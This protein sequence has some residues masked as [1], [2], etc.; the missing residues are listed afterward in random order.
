MD[1][2]FAAQIV[3]EN[4]TR[5]VNFNE[6]GRHIILANDV[7][8]NINGAKNNEYDTTD[9]DNRSNVIEGGNISN[10]VV[11]S[12]EGGSSSIEEGLN[13]S[14]ITGEKID[15]DEATHSKEVDTT[16]G[17]SHTIV[18]GSHV[19]NEAEG[20]KFIYGAEGGSHRFEG[21]PDVDH[22]TREESESYETTNSY[23]VVDE[24]EEGTHNTDQ[25]YDTDNKKEGEKNKY[26]SSN[27][28]EEWGFDI[29][30]SIEIDI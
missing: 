14:N 24:T 8:Q 1:N 18:G 4:E 6:G 10:A 2:G 16:E 30:Q 23:T 15:T 9:S 5:L 26:D 7:K 17:G 25:G 3:I 20:V 21:G 12:K 22:E 13:I 27:A 11:N 19:G 29:E 28:T